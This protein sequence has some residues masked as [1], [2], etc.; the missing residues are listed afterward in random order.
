MF[1]FRLRSGSVG[2]ITAKIA[3]LKKLELEKMKTVQE[4]P[5]K[6]KKAE[7]Q[8]ETLLDRTMVVLQQQSRKRW[9]SLHQEPASPLRWRWLQTWPTLGV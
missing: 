3:Q 7:E 6:L 5:E 1:R 8:G 9:R 2:T 4:L